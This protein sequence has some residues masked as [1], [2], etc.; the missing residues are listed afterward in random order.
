MQFPGEL[1]PESK[2]TLEI[3]SKFSSLLRPSCAAKRHFAFHG[4]RG[5][6]KSHTVAKYLVATAAQR[7]VRIGCFREIQKSIATSVKQLLDD[8]IEELRIP[9]F[10]ST[11]YS[12]EHTRTGSKFLFAG[13][14]TNPDSIKSTEGMDIGWVEEANRCSQT[15]LDL[16]TPTF[17][18]PNSRIIYTW[19]RTNITDPVD[20]MFLGGTPPPNSIVEQVNWRDNPYFKETALPE[21]MEW[22]KGRDRDK[23]LHVWEGEPLMRSEARV[24]THWKEDD[25]DLDVPPDCVPRYGA[26]WGLRDPAVLVKM[27]RWG[28]TLYI[29]REAYRVGCPIDQLPA[30]FAGSD[31]RSPSRWE[32]PSCFPGVEGA[33]TG[34][35]IADSSRPDTIGYLKDRGFHIKSAIKGAGSVEE[36]V[37]FLQSHDI[38]VHPSCKH[39]M[40]ELAT[41]SYKVDK[42]TDGVLPELQDTD[43]HTID[44]IRYALEGERRMKRSTDGPMILPEVLDVEESYEDD[45]GYY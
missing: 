26:D 18:N 27:F 15:S 32:N 2:K 9:G 5:G 8:K 40:A 10:R 12:L 24:F 1:V 37:E 3:P 17:R 45:Y 33:L 11:Q 44:S 4:G 28:R 36:G 30:L 42:L 23:W 25:L 7:E 41:Y 43:N 38:V 6:G 22:L 31:P 21:E 34:I 14:R 20:K 13:L 39:V 16:L 35:I 29:A 19:N